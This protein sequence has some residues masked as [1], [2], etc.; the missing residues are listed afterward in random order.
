[1]N[2]LV[3]YEIDLQIK[4]SCPSDKCNQKLT[5]FMHKHIIH[6]DVQT[7]QVKIA[8]IEGDLIV[9]IKE[10]VLP[11]LASTIITAKFK[12]KFQKEIVYAFKRLC[13]A[14]SNAL[15]YASSNLY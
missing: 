6:Y 4:G 12:C 15:W 8:G 5:D 9:V 1:M 7:R 11:T 13:S 2:S 10:Q 14:D 3:I